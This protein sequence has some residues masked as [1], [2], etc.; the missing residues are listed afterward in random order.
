MLCKQVYDTMVVTTMQ[1]LLLCRKIISSTELSILQ[2]LI[3]RRLDSESV[4][5]IT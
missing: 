2:L 1:N 3:D 4:K 5:M